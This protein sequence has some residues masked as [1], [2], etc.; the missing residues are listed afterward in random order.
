[1]PVCIRIFGF[2]LLVAL[3]SGKFLD[4]F[5]AQ[6]S[7]LQ[8]GDGAAYPPGLGDGNAETV[9][10]TAS[11][12]ASAPHLSGVRGHRASPEPCVLPSLGLQY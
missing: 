5:E 6:L 10:F 2:C 11:P 4:F 3:T 8:N 9:D 12:E 1:M 7:H